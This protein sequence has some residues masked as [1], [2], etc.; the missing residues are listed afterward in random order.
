MAA[1]AHSTTSTGPDDYIPRF[2]GD[3][4]PGAMLDPI[5]NSF[6][7]I[8]EDDPSRILIHAV[9]E[10]R[11]LTAAM[12]RD[13]VAAIA[14]VLETAGIR[15]GDSIVTQAANRSS[16]ISLVLACFERG[17]A[18]MPADRNMPI[19][20]VLGLVARFGCAGAV[21]PDTVS[22][23]T[24]HLASILPGGLALHVLGTLDER[25]TYHDVAMMKLTSGSTGLPK[26]TATSVENI[27]QDIHAI[28]ESM[29]IRADDVQLAVLPLSHA[30]GFGNLIGP[31]VCQGT[32]LVLRDTFVPAQLA[33]DIAT[34]RI[35]IM[36]GVPF[37]FDHML[38]ARPAD[39]LPPSLEIAITAG[40]PITFATVQRFFER[41]GIKIHSFYGTSETGGIA[42]DDSREVVEPVTVGRPMPGVTIELKPEDTAPPDGGRVHV[43]GKAVAGG[44]AG[45]PAASAEGFVDGGFLTGDVGF[46][47]KRGNLNLVGRVSTFVNVAGHKVQP[48]EVEQTLRQFPGVRDVRVIGAADARRG[49]M[50]VACVVADAVSVRIAALREFCAA[51]LSPHKI[52]REFVFVD[53]LPVD[54]RGKSDRRAIETLVARYLMTR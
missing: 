22:L 5:S 45:D 26:A 15:R 44:Y 7:R 2:H 1:H 12:L 27:W 8:A 31:L 3:S 50:L 29:D 49:E 6:Q 14:A 17:V 4:D 52:P 32:P 9:S 30:Y 41:F 47:D 11:V 38:E 10:R 23:P 40:A 53:A 19:A 33:D 39:G 42:Y 20:E 43:S 51:R 21:L 48:A 16:F 28:A 18:F 36:P 54:L 25:R 46:F 37:M 13:E 34:Y 35:R 24:S